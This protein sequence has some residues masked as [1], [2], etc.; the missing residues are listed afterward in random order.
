[1]EIKTKRLLL[2]QWRNEDLRQLIEMNRDSKVMEFIGPILSEDQSKA[3]M[4][5]AQ[6]RTLLS[7]ILG[8]PNWFHSPLHRMC[9]RDA[10]WRRLD[11]KETL[12]M[13]L[14]IPISRLII[15]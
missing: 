1:M 2:R 15:P 5:R 11:F 8:S 3:I 6:C 10:L 14:T 13:T 12:L 9:D 4:E 7:M